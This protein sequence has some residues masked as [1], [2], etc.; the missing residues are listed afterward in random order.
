MILMTHEKLCYVPE[1][2]QLN[3][4]KTITRDAGTSKERLKKMSHYIF[5][6]KSTARLCSRVEIVSQMPH[7]EPAKVAGLLMEEALISWGPWV[8]SKTPGP[9]W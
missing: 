2:R 7:G 6:P 9:P 1:P 5:K 4:H 8:L 3:H